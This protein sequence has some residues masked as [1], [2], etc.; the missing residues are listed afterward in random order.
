MS[1]NIRKQLGPVR[2]RL[3]DRIIEVTTLIT[4]NA[5]T[6]QLENVR[7]KLVANMSS[8]ETLIGKLNEV[9]AKT[10]DET[11]LIENELERCAELKMDADEI[12][13]ALN[14]QIAKNEREDDTT[15]LEETKLMENEKVQQ[16]LEKLKVEIE[17]KRLEITKL[18]NEDEMKRNAKQVRLPKI[19]LPKFSG[20]ITAWPAFWDSY[21]STIHNNDALSK[22]DKFK[23]LTSCLEDEAKDTLKGFTLTEAQYDIA[24]EHLKERY[25]DREFIIHRHYETLSELPRSKNTT[26]ELR[27]MFNTLETRIR[28]LESLGEHVENK[29]IVA[30][31]KSKFPAEFNLKLEETRD[32][33][34]NVATL[35]KTIHKLIVAREKAGEISQSMEDGSY[36]YSTEG[37]LSK[38]MKIR[39]AFCNKGHWSNE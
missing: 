9:E 32:G 24:V 17:C 33:E 39:C 18:K 8:Y 27:Q 38:D 20:N 25:D 28:S 16:E 19:E 15:L 12:L 35:R 30:L 6:E 29:Q 14:E 3:S 34:W 2:K 21:C 31:V 11:E 4:N 5:D 10:N 26:E 37:L 1:T 7:T 13:H 36:G 22:I 23:Y